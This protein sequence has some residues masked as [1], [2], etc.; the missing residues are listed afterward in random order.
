MDV[1]DR[2][3]DR[4]RRSPRS[5]ALRPTQRA[6]ARARWA[7]SHPRREQLARPAA[8]PC[9]EGVSP[10]VAVAPRGS[11]R[12]RASAPA[13]LAGSYRARGFRTRRALHDRARG[14]RDPGVLRPGRAFVHP[15]RRRRSLRN[16]FAGVKLALATRIGNGGEL[17]DAQ[18]D[19][20]L[21][22][23]VD[24]IVVESD[25]AF[26]LPERFA[27]AGSVEARPRFGS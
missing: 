11:R 5:A 16:A 22:A 10:T 7:L 6:A 26:A 25:G 18:F 1:C 17:L 9:V 12:V 27:R 8:E 2:P 23:G 20:H 15:A 4:L 3:P 14:L 24:V 21:A 19:F 13:Q